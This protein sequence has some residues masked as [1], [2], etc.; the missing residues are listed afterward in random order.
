MQ[1]EEAYDTVP[2]TVL[3]PCKCSKS[4]M[5]LLAVQQCKAYGTALIITIRHQQQP[6]ALADLSTAHTWGAS[7]MAQSLG[8]A[9]YSTRKNQTGNSCQMAAEYACSNTHLPS[10]KLTR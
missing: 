8:T 3:D 10:K 7:K 2:I 5:A 4:I 9:G 1:Q 6:L